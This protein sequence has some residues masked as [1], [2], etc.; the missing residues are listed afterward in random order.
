M[1]ICIS[2]TGNSD[3]ST[4]DPRFGRAAYFIIADTESNEIDSV[5]NTAAVTG[6]GAG[7]TSGQFIVE[8]DVKAIITGNVGPNAMSVLEVANIEIYKGIIASVK[9]NIEKFKKGELDKI[10][11]TVSSHYG[12]GRRAKWR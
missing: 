2:S 3:V 7:V 11:K 10:D 12:M 5:E 8:R 9:D 4:L 6:G 1:K